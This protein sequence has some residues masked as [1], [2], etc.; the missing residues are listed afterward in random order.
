MAA[1]DE[2]AGEI[3]LRHG[4]APEVVQALRAVSQGFR[5]W[6]A[7]ADVTRVL[8]DG[9]RI[10]MRDRTLEVLHRPGHSPTDTVFHD[11]ERRILI[12]ADH[13][14]AHISSNPLLVRPADGGERPRALLNYLESLAQ[15]REMDLDLVLPGHGDPITD[16]RTLIDQRLPVTLSLVIGY[17]GEAI[18]QYSH[19]ITHLESR[20]YFLIYTLR[21]SIGCSK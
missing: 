2:F 14:L 3:M 18:Q 5:A 7:R 13:L 21:R 1:E 12:A 20:Y 16:H 10:V 19:H 8:R 4:I 11:A 17:R 9:E 15:T 6:G